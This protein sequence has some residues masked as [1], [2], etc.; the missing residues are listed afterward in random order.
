MIKSIPNFPG[1]FAD[2]QGNIWSGFKSMGMGKGRSNTGTPLRKL[3]PIRSNDGYL[4][5]NVYRNKKSYS[6][7][8][9]RLVLEAFNG[10]CPKGYWARHLDGDGTNNHKS[11][12]KWDTPSNNIRDK[13]RHGTMPSQIG[14]KNHAAK[15]NDEEV[16]D[17]KF[18][19][20][21]TTFTQEAISEMFGVTRQ[22]IGKIKNKRIWTHV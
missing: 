16:K 20:E 8:I 18:L 2:K 9:H 3:K 13:I 5:V 1:Y 14:E 11:N 21:H 22:L 12:L 19:L 17:I 4:A 10:P 7:R 15:L 6:V